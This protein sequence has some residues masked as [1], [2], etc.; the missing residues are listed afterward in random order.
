V[1]IG[2]GPAGALFGDILEANKEQSKELREIRSR[3]RRAIETR[4]KD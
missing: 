4:P 1:T 3:V 2:D